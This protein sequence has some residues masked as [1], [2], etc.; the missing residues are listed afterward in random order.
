MANLKFSRGGKLFIISAPSG[1]G[2]TS[3]AREAYKILSRSFPLK[4]VIT[5]TSRAPRDKEVNGIDY[6]FFSRDEFIQKERA[7]F[8]LETTE[9]NGELYGSPRSIVDELLQG[10]SFLMVTTLSGVHA[11]TKYIKNTVRIWITVDSIETLKKRLLARGT[12]SPTDLS[13][14]LALAL[15]EM[16]QAE[17]EKFYDYQILNNNFNVATQELVGIITHELSELAK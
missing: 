4:R 15:Q 3:L 9:Y 6:H 11:I 17:Q 13:H 16:Q 12:I 14:R 7:G 2:K 5:C 8:F 1:A 10:V